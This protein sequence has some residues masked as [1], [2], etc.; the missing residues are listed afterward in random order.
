M[1]IDLNIRQPKNKE[2]KIDETLKGG[3]LHEIEDES[4]NRKTSNP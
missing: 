3:L 4:I 1:L 2:R